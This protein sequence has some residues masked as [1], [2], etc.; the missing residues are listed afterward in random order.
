MQA[1]TEIYGL[2][3]AN[4]QGLEPDAYYGYIRNVG[5]KNVVFALNNQRGAYYEQALN[6]P[7]AN[8]TGF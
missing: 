2:V 6:I 1:S 3:I 4:G 7:N 8:G 5:V